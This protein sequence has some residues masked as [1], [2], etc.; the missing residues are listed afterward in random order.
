MVRPSNAF[1]AQATIKALRKVQK[2]LPIEMQAAARGAGKFTVAFIRK[3]RFEKYPGY[4]SENRQRRKLYF[5]TG[6]LSRSVRFT[7]IEKR[8]GIV[9]EAGRGVGDT[10]A[11]DNEFGRVLIGS[12]PIPLEDN[13]TPTGRRKF[14]TVADALSAGGHRWRSPSTGKLL[15]RRLKRGGSKA[16]PF[17]YLFVIVGRVVIPPRFKFTQT[18]RSNSILIKDR[19]KRFVNANQK[20]IAAGFGR[21]GS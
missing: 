2:R 10:R 3:N 7:D 21:A 8:G 6:A 20:S 9:I 15:I 17:E 14:K 5:R 11:P 1:Q 18:I 4:R 19:R 16:R 12:I 13:T